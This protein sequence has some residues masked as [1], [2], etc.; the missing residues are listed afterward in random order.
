MVSG[1]RSQCGE[2][3]YIL[4]GVQMSKNAISAFIRYPIVAC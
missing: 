4:V 3:A 1:Y 2:L